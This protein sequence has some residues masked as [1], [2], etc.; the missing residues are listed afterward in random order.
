[1][2][3][4]G[5]I[6]FILCGGGAKE[7][8]QI[9][10]LT[11]L[12]EN[13]IIPNYI[14]GISVGALNGAKLLENNNGTKKEF[15]QSIKELKS[16]W[17]NRVS[18]LKKVYSIN[19]ISK[20][21]RLKTNFLFNLKPIKNLIDSINYKGI[22][23]SPIKFDVIV[24]RTDKTREEIF[25]NRDEIT[26]EIFKKA[27]LASA[28]IPGIFPFVDING[29]KYFDGGMTCPLPLY[30]P[31]KYDYDSVFVLSSEA[32]PTKQ[33]EEKITNWIDSLNLLA[34]SSRNK[35]KL[36]EINWTEAINKDIITLKN[37][38]KEIML[39]VPKNKKKT[40][41]NIFKKISKD[42]C[43]IRKKIINIFYLYPKSLPKTL[44]TLS[45]RPE[46]IKIAIKNG[47]KDAIDTINQLKD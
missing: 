28:S 22:L 23:Q 33:K 45:F 11:A 43:F 41:E 24:S 19:K 9:G 20:I 46:D 32:P 7:A 27:I 6:C 8:V 29:N 36:M 37:L 15:L 25:S 2:N 16:M 30:L 18:L 42:F 47:Y 35:L 40:F 1:M 14:I 39:L 4:F 5:K 12:I 38:F 21:I 17:I 31:A 10:Q 26:P 3:S 44:K 13:N 34:Q